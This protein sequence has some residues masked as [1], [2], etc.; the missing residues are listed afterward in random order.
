MSSPSAARSGKR[1]WAD[2]WQRFA[3][4]MGPA[5]NDGGMLNPANADKVE[6]ASKI[7]DEPDVKAAGDDLQ[8]YFENKCGTDHQ[9][10]IPIRG[11]RIRRTPAAPTR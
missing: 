4:E 9:Q 8:A 3:D 5:L 1:T 6:A 10:L 2:A 7:L 11:S